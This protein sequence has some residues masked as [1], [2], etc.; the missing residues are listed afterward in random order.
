MYMHSHVGIIYFNNLV[1]RISQSNEAKC[2]EVTLQ[3]SL[4]Y[5]III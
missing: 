4:L 1:I 5:I 3:F 2:A